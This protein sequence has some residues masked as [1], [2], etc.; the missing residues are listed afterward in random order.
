MICTT[1]DIP[2]SNLKPENMD[3]FF[4]WSSVDISET[5]LRSNEIC[6][7]LRGKY[8]YYVPWKAGRQW[9]INTVSP[10]SVPTFPCRLATLSDWVKINTANNKLSHNKQQNILMNLWRTPQTMTLSVYN[11]CW[12][13]SL[14]CHEEYVKPSKWKRLAKT[15]EKKPILLNTT[16]YSITF[17]KELNILLSSK[18]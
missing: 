2:T 1:K 12:T 17:A 18:T 6:G 16:V 8:F 14:Q 3:P 5:G 11:G 15:T 7:N 10:G 13:Q 9:I 4:L